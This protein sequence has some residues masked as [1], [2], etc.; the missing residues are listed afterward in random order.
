MIRHFLSLKDLSKLEVDFIIQRAIELKKWRNEGYRPNL[1]EKRVLGMIFEKSSTRTRVSFESSMVEGGGGSIF[2]TNRDSQM[3]RGESIADTS[4][5]ISRM[6]DIIMIRTH[7]HEAVETFSKYSDVP[8]INGLTK[9]LH[10]CQILAD[11]VTYFEFRGNIKNKRVAWIGDGNNMCN[12]YI[13]AAD[14]MDFQLIIACPKGFEPSG[15]SEKNNC[16]LVANP[17]LAA[18]GAD[19]VVTDVWASMGDES[20]KKDRE[21]AFTKFEVNQEVM[22]KAN[23]DAL[24]M[25]CLPAYR[26]LEVSKEVL[27]GNN[28]VVWHEAE[29]RL[30]SQKA[31]IEFLLNSLKG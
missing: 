15:I 18:D 10:P 5:V 12:S 31:L 22:D 20:E 30:H 21:R 24:F 11:L 17:C 29:N 8:V 27:E 9:A 23:S 26:G 16:E 7:S 3:G 14:L 19:L 28:S 4:R 13:E 6:V 25:H 2:L 1:F